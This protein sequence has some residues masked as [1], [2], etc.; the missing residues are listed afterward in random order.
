[1]NLENVISNY[2]HSRLWEEFLHEIRYPEPAVHDNF[3][4]A[5]IYKF[6]V[7]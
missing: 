6:Y 2:D 3:E 7:L 4:E 1:M 5:G